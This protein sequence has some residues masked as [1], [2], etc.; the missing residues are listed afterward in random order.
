MSSPSAGAEARRFGRSAGLLSAG[1]GSAG[2]LT[3]AYFALASHNLDSTS[4]G[5]I[6]VLWSAVFV[7]ISVLYRPVEQLLSRTIAER[8]AHGEESGS[9][10]RVAA[11]IQLG[12]AALCALAMLALRRQLQDGLLSGAEQ[13]YWVLLGAVVGFGASF[14]ARGY[15][16][17]NRHFGLLAGL[18]VCESASRTAFALAVAI[19]LANGQLAVAMGIAAAPLFSLIVVPAAFRARAREQVAGAALDESDKA[20]DR[21]SLGKG[22][23]F[24]AAVFVVMLSEQ[25]MLNAG[26]L[27]VRGLVDASAAGYIFNVLMLARAPLLVFQ[28]VATSLLPHL[29]RLR[30]RGSDGDAAFRLS[31]VATLRAVAG[32]TAFVAVVVAAAGP[33]LMQIAFSDRFSYDRAG[34]LL[35][36]LGMGLY[37]SATTINQAALAQGRA[38]RAAICWA[39]SAAGFLVWGLLP[40][41][42]EAR[43]IELGFAGAALVLAT[44][45]WAV[46]RAPGTE[47]GIAPG[48]PVEIEARLASADEAS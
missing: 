30:A 47:P 21:V 29:T 18:L 36:T 7:S 39:L 26:P 34:L 9:A 13:L 2:V 6:V 43:R 35:V 31:V 5:E 1:V 24:A 44:T 8:Q 42:E 32:F 12:V 19:G 37:L 48:S 15:L 16:A 14:F 27:I 11:T 33:T 3:Y 28:G 20:T 46:H 41:L 38:R 23:G 17:G 45:L 25:T 22:G 10:L 4:Y 40:V